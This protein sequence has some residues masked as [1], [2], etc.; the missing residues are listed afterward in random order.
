MEEKFKRWYK[1]GFLVLTL[2]AYWKEPEKFAQISSEIFDFEVKGIEAEPDTTEIDVNHPENYNRMNQYLEQVDS[3]EN[4]LK[5][6]DKQLQK[7][8]SKRVVVINKAC[9]CPNYSENQKQITYLFNDARRKLGM[10]RKDTIHIR[11]STTKI[12]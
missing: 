8:S 10:Y 3:L 4:E 7:A 9:N 2:I 6:K 5:E 11:N 12:R 1:I